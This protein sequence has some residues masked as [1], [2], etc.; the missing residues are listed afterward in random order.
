VQVIRIERGD[1]PR[2]PEKVALSLKS[3]E[4]DPWEGATERFPEGARLAGK[5]A[6]VEPF[7]AFVELAPGVEGLVHISELGAGR[8]HHRGQ[9]PPGLRPG[10]QKHAKDAVKVGESIEVRVLGVDRERRRI[11]LGLAVAGEEDEAPTSVPAARA[12]ASLGTLG[13]LLRGGG[14]KK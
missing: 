1:D 8:H 3:L 11:S 14:K 9:A 13:D 2:K 4:R 7:G 5:V 10:A 12:P 6:R